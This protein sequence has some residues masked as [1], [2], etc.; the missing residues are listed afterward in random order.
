MMSPNITP[1]RCCSS[2]SGT[3][4]DT[5]FAKI[6]GKSSDIQPFFS[7][8]FSEIQFKYRWP[9]IATKVSYAILAVDN[10]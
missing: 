9:T 8:A 1:Y 2:K 7:H 5:I 10:M 4:L 3:I 6:H